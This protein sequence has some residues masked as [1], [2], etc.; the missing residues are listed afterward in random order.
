MGNL[1][2]ALLFVAGYSLAAL[3]LLMLG[4]FAV[5]GVIEAVR[6]GRESAEISEENYV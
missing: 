2:S 5:V 1:L 3:T 6:K 4:A